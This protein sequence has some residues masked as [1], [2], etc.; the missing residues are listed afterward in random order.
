MLK[1]KISQK[2]PLVIILTSLFTGL[3]IGIVSFLAE[4]ET[5]G[6]ANHEK[7][8]ALLDAQSH[9]LHSYLDGISEDIVIIAKN[10]AVMRAL[11]SFSEGW[12]SIEGDPEA[13]LQQHYITENPHPT[14]QKEKLDFAQDGSQYSQIHAYYHPWFRELLEKR[15][16]Y[17][18]FLFN[19]KGDLL[20]S[21][22]K[23]SDYATNMNTGKWKDTDL[24]NAFRKALAQNDKPHFF[25]FKPYGPSADAP[26]SFISR[27]IISPL[28][29]AVGVLVYQM[30]IS[31]INGV[32][33][34]K[35]GLGETGESY[36]VGSDRLMR[37]ASRFVEGSILKQKVNTKAVDFALNG[38][39]GVVTDLNYQG[40][41]S[42]TAYMPFDYMG[43][44]WAIIA[45]ETTEELFK[46]LLKMA[47]KLVIVSLLATLM[48]SFIG[49]LIARRISKPLEHV[50]G[51]VKRLQAKETEFDVPYQGRSDEVG[52]LAVA[53][54]DF[55]EVSI[56]QQEEE[57]NK[58]ERAKKIDQLVKSFE[59]SSSMAIEAMAVTNEQMQST[60]SSLTTDVESVASS[61]EELSVSINEV[62][63]QITKTS[64]AVQSTAENASV[65]DTVAKSLV[66]TT[67]S[68]NHVSQM[69]AAIAEKI[70]L[71]ALNATIESA[72]AGEAGKGFAVVASEVK[73]LANQTSNSTEQITTL[74]TDIQE[75]ADETVEKLS[76]IRE[77]IHNTNKYAAGISS[78]AEEQS[79]ATSEISVMMQKT[80][81]AT[82]QMR[83]ASQ[84]FSEHADSLGEEVKDFLLKIRES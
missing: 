33:K 23:E 69:I 55:R 46:P 38:Q 35:H 6:E 20:Y 16:Y 51:L 5:L 82:I 66:E 44:R 80:A 84:Q 52:D 68:I 62:T 63:S 79:T 50:I 8:Y 15:G 64:E 22:F 34:V 32:M 67:A 10:E 83:Q 26:A 9:A 27:A 4:E 61:T 21:V 37:T 24:A 1:L 30:P 49:Y 54:D 42:F 3:I 74:I 59:A 36:V 48:A 2:I 58:Q 12:S 70:N 56:T 45:E 18:V 53:L 71:L 14:G 47:Y 25:D 17:D 75:V 11:T 65:A 78:A 19:N 39:T 41:E 31:R 72:H 81:S 57:A 73:N 29:R 43:A 77:N 76:V 40:F 7:M 13:Y 28:G 60:L